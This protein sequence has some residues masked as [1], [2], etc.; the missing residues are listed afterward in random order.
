MSQYDN[1][2]SDQIQQADSVDL[3]GLLQS[4]GEEISKD[5]REYSWKRHDSLKINPEKNVWFQNSTQK[6]GGTIRFI[7]TFSDELGLDCATFPK[8]MRYLIGE[9]LPDIPVRYP[10]Q[11]A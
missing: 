1:F 3:V 8:A 5:G 9:S 10:C 4:L 2:T 6:H 11:K 7:M